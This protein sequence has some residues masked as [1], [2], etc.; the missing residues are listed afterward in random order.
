MVCRKVI[1]KDEHIVRQFIM[2]R[3]DG[4]EMTGRGEGKVYSHFDKNAAAVVV[5]SRELCKA[6]WGSGF[7][8]I[9]A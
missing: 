9:V 2:D 7:H 5:H 3:R 8:F 1:N 4:K 6:G